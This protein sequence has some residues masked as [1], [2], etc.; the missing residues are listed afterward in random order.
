MIA[1]TK[2][3]LRYSRRLP[4]DPEYLKR[5]RKCWGCKLP[6][7]IHSWGPPGPYCTGP[8][9]YMEADEEDEEALQ[10]QLQKLKLAELELAKALCIR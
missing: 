4:Q 8:A 2:I 1:T 3:H 5:V 7:D 10:E 9:E 6:H